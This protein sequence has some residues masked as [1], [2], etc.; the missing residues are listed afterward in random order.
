MQ[1]LFDLH[2]HTRYSDGKSSFSENVKAAQEKGI[3][4]GAS[5]HGPGHS[6]FGISKQKQ[7]RL[8]SEIEATNK[9]NAKKPVLLGTEANLL[10]GGTTDIDRLIYTPDYAILGYHKAA[11]T[12]KLHFTSLGN[13]KK[14]SALL[15]DSLIKAIEDPRIIVIAHPGQYIPVNLAALSEA[16]AEKGVLIEI[17]E[18]HSISPEE[19]QTA[20]KAGA[21]FLLSS[22]AHH[23]SNI[24][25]M[26]KSM[27]SIEKSGLDIS[28]IVNLSEY[29]W[30]QGLRIDK[31]L[32][33]WAKNWL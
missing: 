12:P 11:F 14:R 13:A 4:L 26:P 3:G 28:R 1:L 30:N 18:R 32:E 20:E 31:K 6:L 8:Q 15:T 25:N 21:H 2:T 16:A 9:S 22:D 10:D 23:F 33:D 17:N 5:D 27:A 29:R 7:R 19:I 24:G